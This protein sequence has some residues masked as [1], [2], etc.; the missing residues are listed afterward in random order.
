MKL[1][2][3]LSLTFAAL[4]MVACGGADKSKAP[5]AT[6]SAATEG[7]LSS[8][9]LVLEPQTD[10]NGAEADDGGLPEVIAYKDLK[11]AF[12]L[13]IF[14][15]D[16]YIDEEGRW[17]VDLVVGSFAMIPVVAATENGI[18]IS[19]VPINYSNVGLLDVRARGEQQGKTETDTQGQSVLVFDVLGEPREEVILVTSQGQELEVVINVLSAQVNNYSALASLEGVLHWK[20]L[21]KAEVMH[22]PGGIQASFPDHIA[23]L[24]QTEVQ[25]VGFMMPLDATEK[26]THFVLTSSPP[27]CFYHIPGG[28]AGGVEVF[29]KK[30]IAV[31]WEPILLKGK[32]KIY[33]QNKIGVIYQLLDAEQQDLILPEPEGA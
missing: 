8:E 13:S 7:E 5:N 17:V 3:L 15:E 23:D 33:E 11:E 26:Q 16:A 12:E 22:V 14:R 18:G 1:V 30:P 31:G 29:A 32:L 9:E 28:I 20:E 4:L 6:Q 25:L 21:V 2:A 24:H 27:S 10:S 19:G